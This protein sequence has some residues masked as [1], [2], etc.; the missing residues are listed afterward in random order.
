LPIDLVKIKP[1]DMLL[2]YQHGD[3]SA[4]QGAPF[5]VTFADGSKRSGALD[6][7]GKALLTAVPAGLAQV[8]YGEDARKSADGHD[9][10]NPL[11]GWMS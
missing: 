8:H 3:G 4:V 6:A 1:N 9:E 7:A 11:T 2:E 5:E 10:K